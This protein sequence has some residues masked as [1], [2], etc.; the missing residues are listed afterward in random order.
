MTAAAT[1]PK[2]A[3]PESLDAIL[4]ATLEEYRSLRVE[5]AKRREALRRAEMPVV[6]R[7]VETERAIMTRIGD[8]DR[9]RVVAVQ[10][11][12]KRLGVAAT[13]PVSEIARKLGPSGDGLLSVAAALREEI[14]GCR[15]DSSVVRAAAD[16][17]SQHLVGVFQAVQ[18]AFAG[19]TVYGRAGRVALAAPI[20]SIDVKS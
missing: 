19:A 3:P 12:S 18:Q 14:E 4:A 9:R 11:L 10:G 17:L 13:A 7:S 6:A 5:I 16:A 2:P 1:R 20:R 8:L 15:R